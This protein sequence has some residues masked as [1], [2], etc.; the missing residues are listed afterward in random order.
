[1]TTTDTATTETAEHEISRLSADIDQL[2]QDRLSFNER[3]RDLIIL[4]HKDLDWCTPGINRALDEL[5]LRHFDPALASVA[6]I[7]V[8]F[9]A[10]TPDAD[11]ARR[12]AALAL[13]CH[14]NDDDIEITSSEIAIELDRDSA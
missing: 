8:R 13:T 4:Q 11:D 2:R 12:W 3:V 1:M 10:H 14:S 5:G 7:R 6:T 9:R